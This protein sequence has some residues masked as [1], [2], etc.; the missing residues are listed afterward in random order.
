MSNSQGQRKEIIRLPKIPRSSTPEPAPKRQRTGR[1]T[2]KNIVNIPRGTRPRV[3]RSPR[4][5]EPAEP[6]R[7]IDSSERLSDPL[8]DRPEEEVETAEPAAGVIDS[9]ERSSDP[10]GH[11]AATPGRDPEE[12][13]IEDARVMSSLARVNDTSERS[14]QPEERQLMATSWILPEVPTS[15]GVDTGA[16]PTM[17]LEQAAWDAS[18]MP[19]STGTDTD[20]N[21]RAVVSVTGDESD[22]PT[23]TGGGGGT[24]GTTSTRAIDNDGGATS[25]Q[26]NSSS[27]LIS[28]EDSVDIVGGGPRTGTA[29]TRVM[30]PSERSSRPMDGTVAAASGAQAVDHLGRVRTLIVLG[31][32]I[33]LRPPTT[34]RRPAVTIP[35]V[36][37]LHLVR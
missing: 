24:D 1:N 33:P 20:G 6:T 28:V 4:R 34:V 27:R 21:S 10:L 14:T 22:G 23:S 16:M 31:Q 35:A 36:T 2:S 9:S 3:T 11:Q 29:P 17:D 12:A 13:A 5:V 37:I 7:V 26:E 8:E 19:V 15:M 30:D 25:E 32:G 18:V